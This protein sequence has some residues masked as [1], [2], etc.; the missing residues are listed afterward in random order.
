MRTTRNL[1]PILTRAVNRRRCN[2]RRD[3]DRDLQLNLDYTP[4]Q[5]QQPHRLS[6]A[7][8]S[9]DD[10]RDA[11]A[12]LLL[13]R[14]ETRLG[15][16]QTRRAGGGRGRDATGGQSFGA[17]RQAAR[18]RASAIFRCGVERCPRSAH[19]WQAWAVHEAEDATGDAAPAPPSGAANDAPE[20]AAAARPAASAVGDDARDDDSGGPRRSRAAREHEQRE[21]ARERARNR[22]RV[23][24]SRALSVD[25][26]NA[27]AAH[28]WGLLEVRIE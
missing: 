11:H 15:M 1:R 4:R 7:H 3:D 6:L 28:A 13:A 16:Q 8:D 12:W 14:A 21:R 26:G 19:L 17:A 10:E 2:G 25:H 24:F 5:P 20:E 22:A 9:R 18:A 23:L 27:F